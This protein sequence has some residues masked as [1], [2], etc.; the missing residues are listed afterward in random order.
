MLA[1]QA[2]GPET[3]VLDITSQPDGAMVLINGTMSGKTPFLVKARK[4]RRLFHCGLC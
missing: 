2:G 1:E 3:G 4:G